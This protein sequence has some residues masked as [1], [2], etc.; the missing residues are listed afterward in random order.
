MYVFEG[1]SS[2]SEVPL[3]HVDVDLRAGKARQ[4][5]A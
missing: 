2:G 3:D 4:R 1:H 5:A